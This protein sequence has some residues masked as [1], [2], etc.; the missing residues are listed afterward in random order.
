MVEPATEQIATA[1]FIDQCGN[2]LRAACE[3]PINALLG[4]Q[5]AALQLQTG[6]NRAQRFAQLPE[7]RQVGELIES[8]DL[9]GHVR[10]L[11]GGRWRGNPCKNSSSSLRTNGSGYCRP[12]GRLRDPYAVPS[13]LTDAA[14][15]LCSSGHRWLWVPAFAGATLK[16][17]CSP[18]IAQYLTN[19]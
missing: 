10:G 4:Q 19:M 15:C 8:G 5:H 3:R 14:N 12:D 13:R 2:R 16:G 1:Q 17:L 18:T 7:I 9:V 6:A 11:S